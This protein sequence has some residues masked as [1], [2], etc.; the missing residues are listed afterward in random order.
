MLIGF[1]FL[2]ASLYVS[3]RGAYWDRLCRDVVGRWLVGWLSRACTVAERCILGNSYYGTLIG[4]PTPGI[5]WYNFRPLGWP[6]TGEWAPVRRF[7][8]N[9]FDLLLVHVSFIT[10][11]KAE[12]LWSMLSVCHCVC[13]ILRAR[14]IRVVHVFGRPA[15]W[16]GLGGVGSIFLQFSVGWVGSKMTQVLYFWRLHNIKLQGTVQ[17][18]YRGMKNW[19][20]STN[21]SLYF[22][23]GTRYGRSYNGRPLTA[24][25]FA[26][27][28]IA[29][30]VGLG[31][32]H[33]FRF[34]NLR[35]VGLGRVTENG[36]I[37][38][39]LR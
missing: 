18:K 36:A 6:L 16:V 19:C 32:V 31:L 37:R 12:F 5:Q 34:A 7:L 23:N 26:V 4:N 9:Y 30:W 11:G 14:Y 27:S 22:E 24:D 8:S 28:C 15:C 29:G 25:S 39:T 1:K 20:F 35:W 2:S 3:K 38:T 33:I 10:S 13:H 21:I 17:V